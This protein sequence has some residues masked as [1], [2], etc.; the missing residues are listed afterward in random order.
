MDDSRTV[1][2]VYEIKR[3]CKEEEMRV[4]GGVCRSRPCGLLVWNLIVRIESDD[5]VY[6]N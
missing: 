3:E 6:G 5:I 1:L 2:R 4:S